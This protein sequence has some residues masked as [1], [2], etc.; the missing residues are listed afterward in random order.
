MTDPTVRPQID[1]DIAAVLESFADKMIHVTT[2][3]DVARVRAMV[4]PFADDLTLGGK[5][6]R[7]DHVVAGRDGHPDVRVAVH[8]PVGASGPIPTILHIHGG[9][10]IA[11]GLD[12][13]MRGM[14][15]LAASVGG[16]IVGVE[17]RLA[18]E[19]RYPAA[20]DDCMTALDWVAGP[21]APEILDSAR[22]VLSGMSAGGGLAASTALLARDRGGPRVS[23]LMLICPMLDHRNDSFSA[24]QM[25]GAGSWDRES[26]AVGWSAYL[27]DI[28]ADDVDGYASPAIATSLGGLPPTF[29]DAASAETFRDE[30]VDFASRM[31]REGGDAELHVW[32]GGTHGFDFLAPEAPM[33]VAARTARTQWLSRVISR[34]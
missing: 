28:H 18:P 15:P 22:L 10:L 24:R 13:D 30:C 17:Y 20:I 8:A 1:P 23:A 31:W 2:L 29:I 25:E 4:P 11:G 32:P 27:G 9:G 21:D 7:T 5:Y 33:P 19:N 26:N 3:E 6:A 34:M 12:N 14:V 16:A